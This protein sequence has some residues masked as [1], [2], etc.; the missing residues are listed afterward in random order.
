MNWS[1]KLVVLALAVLPARASADESCQSAT[2]IDSQPM[3]GGIS[4][5][6][7]GHCS[8]D[9]YNA[10][11]MLFSDFKVTFRDTI[12]MFFFTRQRASV[13]VGDSINVCSDGSRFFLMEPSGH[14]VRL[15]VLRMERVQQASAPA[16]VSVQSL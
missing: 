4:C 14:R 9:E 3:V 6:H 11:V 13:I 16:P 12:G 2:V 15:S 1:T 10:I 8:S 5:S 7:N